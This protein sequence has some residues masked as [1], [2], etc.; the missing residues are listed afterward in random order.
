MLDSRGP[1]RIDVQVGHAADIKEHTVANTYK[2]KDRLGVADKV[3]QAILR[4]SNVA[5]TQACYIKTAGANAVEAMRS[6]EDAATQ[7]CTKDAPLSAFDAAD[8]VVERKKRER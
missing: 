3:I 7:T 4:H 1:S 2:S 6:P 8:H 5:V